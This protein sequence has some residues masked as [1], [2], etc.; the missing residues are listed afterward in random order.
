MISIIIPVYN[1]KRYVKEAVESAL[2]QTYLR[3]EVIVID[4]GSHDGTAEILEGIKGIK[5]I[6]KQ[7]GGTGSALNAGITEAKGEWIKWL[8]ADDVMYTDALEQMMTHISK[9]RDYKNCIFYTSYDIINAEGGFIKHYFERPV[10]NQTEEMMRKFFGNGSTTMIHRSIFHKIGMFK[11]IPHSE[12]YEFW[13][14]ALHN[15]I[16]LELIPSYT[17]QYRMHQDQLTNTV[18]GSLDREIRAPYA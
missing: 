16:R 14:R 3:K 4:D 13:L 9:I 17:I 15:G 1:C 2:N 5:I 12:D 8:S 11:E 10:E 18:G 6:T 7:N